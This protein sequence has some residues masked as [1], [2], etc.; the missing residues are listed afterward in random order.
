MDPTREAIRQLAAQM[1][2][3]Q[4]APVE[5]ARQIAAQAANLSN[6]GEL[7]VFAELARTG[8]ENQILEEASLL[9]ADTA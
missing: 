7:A 9:L 4:L 1:I 6:P 2:S 5:G 8:A 3:G